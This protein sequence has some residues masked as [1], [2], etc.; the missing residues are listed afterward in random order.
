MPSFRLG[1]HPGMAATQTIPLITNH[2]HANLLLLTGQV[3][4]AEHPVMSP[5][6]LSVVEP[7]DLMSTALGIARQVA[8]AA[9]LAVRMTTRTMRMRFEQGIDQ[10]LEREGVGQKM[11]R[12][13]APEQL[14]EGTKAAFE[15][16][17]PK[18]VVTEKS[19]I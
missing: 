18:F 19:K 3:Q 5:L 9:P 8:A 7:K 10:T 6:F 11:S 4:P 15:K 1:L 12:V 17:E 14:A 16:R 13:A 2:Q